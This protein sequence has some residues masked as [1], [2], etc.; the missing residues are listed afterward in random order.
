MRRPTIAD[1]AREC[2]VSPT[3]VSFA[4]NG[5]SGISPGRRE[6][7]L[8][9]ADEL[10]WSPSAAAR[11]LSTSR[12]GTI[13]LIVAL[14]P[15]TISRDTF[16]LQLIAGIE[17][18]LQGGPE[19]LM[20]TVV[21]SMD[22][23][24]AAMRRWHAERRVDA[25][26][27]V[28]PRLEDPRPQLARELDLPCVF[29][30]DVRDHPGASGV[31]V[32]DAAT[33]TAL[34][35]DLSDGDHGSL[36]YLH[37][38]RPFRHGHERLRA[39]ERARGWDRRSVVTLDAESV[40]ELTAEVDDAIAEL[41]ADGLPAVIIG[42]DEPI[43]LAVLSALDR[44]GLRVGE[45]L[46]VVSWESTPGLVL[47]APAISSIDRDPMRLGGAVVRVLHR[48]QEG[49]SGVIEEL[50]PPRLVVRESL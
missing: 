44:R 1:I 14:P 45:D 28:N 20:L 32:D 3:A 7:I 15:A 41:A 34:L 22:E 21:G 48:L 19:A 12:V 26:V 38:R 6:A 27:L 8:A 42:E 46:G 10:G 35:E 18:E 31:L 39:L 5:R 47:R 25:I 9:K 37:R 23:E 49:E 40:E 24:L 11:A 13:G 29:I 4:L 43:V 16:Y 36:A 17:A 50:D 30:G 33:M 2:G